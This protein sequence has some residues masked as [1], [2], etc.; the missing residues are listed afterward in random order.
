[1]PREA[2]DALSFLPD[3]VPD[4]DGHYCTFESVFGK[5]TSEEY[6]PSLQSGKSKQKGTP[7]SPSVQHVKNADI[8]IQCEECEMW[9]LVYGKYKLTTAERA[10]LNQ[11]LEDFTFTCGAVLSDLQLEGERLDGEHV[12][13]KG[14][15]CYEPLEKLYYSVGTCE[16]ICVYCCSSEN[17]TPKQDSYPQC[18]DCPE[19]AY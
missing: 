3:P 9:R 5:S 16:P 14:L 10:M 8:M 12:F 18:K 19:R 7:F 2:F 15:R 1:M 6:R 4:E 11:A 17:I 13:V